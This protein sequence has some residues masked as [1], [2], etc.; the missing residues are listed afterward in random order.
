M[1]ADV[2]SW[3]TA[4]L[5]E[6]AAEAQ[7]RER[8]HPS[9]WRRDPEVQTTMESGR[10][11]VDTN[12]E[13]IAVCN[14]DVSARALLDVDPAAVL[15][16]VEVDRAILAEHPAVGPPNACDRCV[17]WEGIDGDG[18]PGLVTYPCRTVL[19]VASRY[20]HRPGWREK[21]KP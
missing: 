17:D 18:V 6:V 16:S 2:V 14:G 12:D 5:D 15:A 11:V 19:L 13:G 7:V 21:W 1:T 8:F 4:T 3:L 10:W 20:R 9:P